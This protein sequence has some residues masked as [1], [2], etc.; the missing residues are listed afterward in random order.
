MKEKP[1]NT[2]IRLTTD[3]EFRSV[4]DRY[5]V[6]LCLFAR[7]YVEDDAIAADIVQ[8]CFIKLWQLREDF[9]YINQVRSFLYTSIRNRALNEL[10]HTK[11]A[12]E[13]IR[14]TTEKATDH[15]FH[16]HVIQ[17]ETYRILLDAIHKLPG[18]TRAIMLLALEGLNNKDIAAR[19]EISP[20]TVH[21]LK[22]AAY[23]KLRVY[24][25]E[26]YYLVTLFF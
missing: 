23:R 2:P 13:Y 25:K 10:Q 8:E 4:F 24:L 19:L 21:T 14:K 3:T 22:K 12:G 15:F 5:Y 9:F 11:V 1:I 17:E 18:Q 6:S 7:Q 20:E 26:Y 16:D